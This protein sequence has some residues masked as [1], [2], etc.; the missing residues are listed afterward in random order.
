MSAKLESTVWLAGGV[1]LK[2]GYR[3]SFWITKIRKNV[4]KEERKIV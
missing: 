2:F 3:S 4:W 1:K